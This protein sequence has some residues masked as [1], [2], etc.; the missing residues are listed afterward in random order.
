MHTKYKMVDV[1]ED[2]LITENLKYEDFARIAITEAEELKSTI[3]KNFKDFEYQ[4][5]S[6]EAMFKKFLEIWKRNNMKIK[7]QS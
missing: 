2:D 6:A 1:T 7:D 3:A 4:G 5:F